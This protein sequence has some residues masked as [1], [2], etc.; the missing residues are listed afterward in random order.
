VTA[1]A[2]VASALRGKVSTGYG[3]LDEALQG[4]FFAGSAILLSASASSEVPILVRNF[5][6]ASKD[7]SLL[8]CRSQS[9]AE[10]V[11]PLEDS[12]LK[13]MICSEKPVPPSKN[14]L[15]GKGIDNLTELNFQITETIGS[16]QPKRIVIEILSDI[17]LRHKALQA[18]KW[19]NEVLEKLRSKGITTLAVLNPYMHAS[20]EAQA[21]ADLF[22]G[23]IEI[24]EKDVDGTLMKFMRVNWIHGIEVAE[25]EFR[26]VDL[27]SE[28]Q[29]V[30]AQITRP[31]HFK[32]PRW[33]T[34]LVGRTAELSKLKDAFNDALNNRS[35]IAAVQGEAGVGKTRL[36]RELAVFVREE[37][38]VV[39]TGRAGEEKIP[40]EPWVELLR[41]YVAQTPGEVLRRM[42]GSSS[43]EVARLLPDI[44]AKIGTIP[45][46]KPLA[47]EQDRI[48]LYEAITQ[49]L[50]S[51]CNEKPLL[52][53]L[54]DMHWADQ[55]SLGL[56]EH[57]VMGSSSFRVL[58]LVGHRTE[59]VSTDS[60]LS[61]TLMKLN[62]ERLLETVSVKDLTEEE[63]TEFI[64]QI[65]G[66]QAISL[67]FADLIYHRTGG[68]PFF[69]EEVLRSLVEDGTIFRTEKRW[70][71][72][73]IQE[74]AVPNTVKTI[75]KSRLSKIDP[76][77]LNVLVLASVIGSEFDFEVLRGV[78]QIDEDKLLEKLE[79]ALASGLLYEPSQRGVFRFVD[80][81]VRELLLDDLS[82]IRRGKH[83]QKIAEAMEK[84][85]SNS[86]NKAAELI[87]SHAYE[88]GD[89]E[90]ATRFSIMAGD[91]NKAIHAYEQAANDYRRALDLIDLEEGRD[92]QKAA[93]MEKLAE[94][95][96]IAGQL[97]NSA[98]Y[99]QETLEIFEKLH[100]SEACARVCL[101][102]SKTAFGT[103]GTAGIRDAIL[104]LR[105]GLKHVEAEPKSYEAA[106]IYARLSI[107]HGMIDEWDEANTW[108][109]RALAVGEKTQNYR[110][111][112]TSLSVKASFL[113]DTGR[114]DE[115]LPLW[116]RAYE[117]AFHHELFEE[118]LYSLL[119]LSGYT[120]PRDLVEARKLL[121]RHLELSKRLNHMWSED[122]AWSSLFILDW[123]KGDWKACLDE[124]QKCSE[125]T[126]RLGL[127]AILSFLDSDR[128]WLSLSMGDLEQAELD[129]QKGLDSLRENPKISDIV[130]YHLG[131]GMLREEQGRVDEAEQHYATCV[132]SFRKWEFTTYPILHI[133]TL[134]HLTSIYAK[135]QELEK[136][137]E[138]SQW[139][140]RLAE[141]LKSD[142]GLALA[143]QAEASLL[144]AAGER[145]GAEE[146]YLKSLELWGK[147][148]WPYYQAKALV[149]YSEAIVETNP[150]ESKRR[151]EQAA[152]IFKKLGAKRDLEKAEAKLS[153]KAQPR[154][155]N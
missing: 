52:L 143:L 88:A 38:V 28:T 105:R 54:D 35:S 134:L 15:P 69:V 2:S 86:L 61:K 130:Y 74:L 110:A 7:A 55:A 120:Y 50:I 12:N 95:Y 22:D 44:A 41:E 37:G 135:H 46:S 30:K 154:S 146:A 84:V 121:V 36:M 82:K 127:S 107:D 126:N 47:E 103:R 62:R 10:A 73:P 63:T 117:V 87:A 21:L 4:G 101:G 125:I 33:L 56:L 32:E 77:T 18:R 115:G 144:I 131:L 23:N 149:A 75:L 53:L 129:F 116:E 155:A 59:D 108:A 83:H 5:L 113:T 141:T 17:L 43:S 25:K 150:N 109:E 106:S 122:V 34:P 8:I 58:T 65:F 139:A 64:K 124:L 147:A 114:I 45:P 151:L 112:A 119:N 89:A 136:A 49:F 92:E 79:T 6:K 81:R 20:E 14:T 11:S 98:L 67:E 70:D 152:E 27:I 102:L 145:K 138:T 1:G 140:K 142:A 111:I 66:E 99:Y 19:L 72:K 96:R 71:R 29:A 85:Y 123:Y 148:G 80:N 97:Q 133:E 91:S 60:P 104:I 9:S 42:L 137:R 93:V 16:V 31:S 94:C 68:N 132:D 40:Y 39:L 13:C 48:R 128:G 51:I 26:L 78:T 24:V 3:R 57:F 90:R 153:A 76:E 100:D 118:A